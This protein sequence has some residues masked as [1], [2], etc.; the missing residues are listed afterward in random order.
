MT[1]ASTPYCHCK[2]RGA[3]SSAAHLYLAPVIKD[4]LR[5]TQIG[6]RILDLGCGNGSLTSTW[7][8]D[9][10]QVAGVDLSESGID[11]AKK[12]FPQISFRSGDVTGDLVAMFGEKTFDAIVSAEVVEHVY[13][14]RKL[15]QNARTLLRPGGRFLLTTPYHGYWKNVALA[16]SG[17]MDSHF[18]ALGDGGHIKFWSSST[19]R[20][21]LAEAGFRH[22]QFRGAGRI[23]Y[24]WKSICA[25]AVRP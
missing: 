7:S 18:T 11:A 24:L 23:P 2:Y 10:D 16:V 8:R 13:N 17:K 1:A 4:W 25:M 20:E 14:P 5:G 6:A 3:E 22:I 9:G 21:L 19:L 12:A 15:V